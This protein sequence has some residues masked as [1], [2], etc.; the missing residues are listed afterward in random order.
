[1]V[2]IEHDITQVTVTVMMTVTVKGDG[3]GAERVG[4]A[5]DAQKKKRK[6]KIPTTSDIHILVPFCFFANIPSLGFIMPV[7]RPAC[8]YLSLKYS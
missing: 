8:K 1:M 3:D 6:E 2:K 4:H 7:S 5:G